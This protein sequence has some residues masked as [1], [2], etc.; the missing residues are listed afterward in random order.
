MIE[1]KKIEDIE[2]FK[3]LSEIQK[4][5]WGFLDLD[6]EPHHLMTRVQKY[7]GLVQGLYFNGKLAGFTYAL[8]ANWK[9]KHFIYSHMTGVHQKYQTQ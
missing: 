8:I 9:G 5:A 4:S 7:G 6:I 2:D 1:L 3:K